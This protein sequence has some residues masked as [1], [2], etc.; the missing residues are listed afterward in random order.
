METRTTETGVTEV[1]G[2]A[3]VAVLWATAIVARATAAMTERIVA[4][5]ET[6]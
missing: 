3:E 2:A 4:E 1:S 5:R 6:G